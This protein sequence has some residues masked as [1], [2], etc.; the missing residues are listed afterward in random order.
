MIHKILL[1]F[2]ILI[3]SSC[4][5]ARLVWFNLPD[6]K[7]FKH[8]PAK[9]IK[10]NPTVFFKETPIAAISDIKVKTR[11]MKGDSIPLE[12][13][14]K[15]QPV[16]AF[17]ITRNDSILYER[18]YDGYSKNDVLTSFSLAK[19][20]MSAL[21]GIAVDERKISNIDTPITA[22]IPELKKN[23]GLEK[24]TV[25]HLLEHRSGIRFKEIPFNPFGKMSSLYYSRYME[26]ILPKIRTKSAPGIKYEY[27]SINTFLLGVILE[28]ATGKSPSAYLEE[29]I[30]IPL[31]MESKASW[32]LDRKDG[33]EKTFCCI[34][35]QARDHAR[36]GTLYLNKG[37]WLNQQIISE[38]W[39]EESLP[40]QPNDSVYSY[41]YHWQTGYCERGD[42][43]AR[44]LYEQYIFVDPKTN[45][46]IVQL[47]RKNY[48]IKF[49]WRDFYRELCDKIN[50]L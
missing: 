6:Q 49:S 27:Q 18:Y 31:G 4:K 40:C 35:A 50:D 14:L 44:G 42:F 1:I 45:L 39:I 8:F 16:I 24:I 37:K 2:F 32:M 15:N 36:F 43:N 30:W 33:K 10:N 23:R 29:K 13:F 47:C 25:K 28:R 48:F 9:E 12:L 26:R 46:V 38:K 20:Y 34:N 11:N 3:F 21:I 5:I 7:D 17:I 19:S 22:Y 41:P